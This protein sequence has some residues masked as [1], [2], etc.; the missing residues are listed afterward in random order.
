MIHDA[1]T[2]HTSFPYLEESS[3]GIVGGIHT[4]TPYTQLHG[5]HVSLLV[6]LQKISFQPNLGIC[7]EMQIQSSTIKLDTPIY[8]PKHILQHPTLL[9]YI[10]IHIKY[11]YMAA[12][13]TRN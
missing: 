6:Y 3:N 7:A 12:P 10:H 13:T 2:F 1:C 11:V 4:C 8:I 5:L 9:G